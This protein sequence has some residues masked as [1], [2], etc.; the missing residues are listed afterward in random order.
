MRSR[1]L[2]GTDA[3]GKYSLARDS[4]AWRSCGARDCRNVRCFP[5]AMVPVDATPTL[6]LYGPQLAQRLGGTI[7]LSTA[8]TETIGQ[9]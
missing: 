3:P 9:G 2:A 6:R 5:D 1:F 7:Q 8:Q 4:S